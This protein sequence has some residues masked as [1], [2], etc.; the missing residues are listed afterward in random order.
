MGLNRSDAIRMSFLRSN[1][2]RIWAIGAVGVVV[3]VIVV[4]ACSSWPTDGWAA[5]AGWVTAAIALTAGLA[6]LAQLREAQQ[7]R[8]EQSQPYV[9]VF[10]EQSRPNAQ[11]IDLIV[12]N[13]GA[14]AAID[15]EVSIDPAPT[16]AVM[17]GDPL[18][19]PAVIP[20]LVPGQE[21]RTLWDGTVRRSEAGLP[22]AHSATASFKDSRGRPFSFSYALDWEPHMKR[23]SLVTFGEHEAAEALRKIRETLAQWTEGRRGL[24]TNVRDG[25]AMDARIREQFENLP[26]GPV[27]PPSRADQPEEPA[28]KVGP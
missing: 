22:D 26:P 24:R 4:G 20:T 23:G 27:N 8:A 16:Q 12:R 9:A 14:T 25:D 7:L 19:L 3:A 6:A 28:I 17:D 13:F 1:T 15:V 11:F 10:M 18:W 5:A 21:W 2:V